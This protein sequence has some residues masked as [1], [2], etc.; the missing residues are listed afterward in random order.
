MTGGRCFG[1]DN[2]E[3]LDKNGA[4]SHV[5]QRINETE[6]AV[7]RNIFELAAK[8]LGQNRIAKQLNAEGVPA[9]RAQQGRPNAWIQ[10][11]VHAVLFRERYRGELVWNKTKKRDRWG[12]VRVKDRPSTEWLRV[13]APALRI[14]PESLWQAAHAKIAEARADT[15]VRHSAPRASKYLLRGMARCAWCNGGMHVR[16]R[17]QGSRS[18]L[19]LYA[20]TS[21]YNRGEAVCRNRVQFPMEIIDRA[22]IGA[23]DDILTPA[24]VDEIIARVRHELDPRN[25]GD[26]RERLEQ[27]IASVDQQIENLADAIAIGGDMPAL[28]QRLTAAHRRRQELVSAMEA[29]DAHSPAPRVNWRLVERRARHLLSEWRALMAKHAQDARPV[30]RELLDG[31]LKFTPIIEE[32]RRDYHV[33]GAI[34]TREFF[35]GII[36]GNESGVPGRFRSDVGDHV[37]ARFSGEFDVNRAA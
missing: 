34:D 23:I 15:Y 25:R 1:Y 12:Q 6:A 13:P 11:S 22:V 35:L 17:R 27:Q 31:P 20:Y 18:R 7:V 14:V 9:P 29:S 19:A 16:T 26:A 10:S 5:E 32:T 8:G 21:H 24:I 3:V 33:A 36:E 2:V 30:L 4:R 28:V 37:R